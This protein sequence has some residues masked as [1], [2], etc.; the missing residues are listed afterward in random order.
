[1][2]AKF[3]NESFD[4]KFDVKDDIINIHDTS[5]HKQDIIEKLKSPM[6]VDIVLCWNIKNG[7]K[8]KNEE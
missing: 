3:Y 8:Q 2:D 6:H 4:E 7:N 1:M 5:I